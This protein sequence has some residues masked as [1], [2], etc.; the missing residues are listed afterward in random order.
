MRSFVVNRLVRLFATMFAVSFITFFMV[1]LLPGD[2]ALQMLPP[3]ALTEENIAR[4]RADLNL[5][6]PLPAR[7]VSWISGVVTG[8]LGRS[9]RTNEP[10]LDSIRARLPVTLQIAAFSI[11]FALI[12]AIPL[13]TISAYKQGRR[14][15][16][17]ISSSVQFMLS[18]PVFVAAVFLI[19]VFAVRLQWLPAT[20]WTRLTNS[21]PGN[22]R[23][24]LLPALSLSLVEIAIYT[25][26]VRADMISTLQENFVLSARAKGLTNRFILFRH[27]L[28]PS[29][30]SLITVVGLNIGTLLGG[31]VVVERIFALPGL[32][33]L[34]IDSIQQ[35][36][37]LVVQGVVLFI[38]VVYVV[39]NTLVDL[40]Y[41]AV[42]P[43]IRV[44]GK[45]A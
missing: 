17:I 28:R 22:L 44:S 45:G 14:A 11:V 40:V 21:V 39:V 43:R 1:N 33:G 42:D 37:L 10:V 30:L 18:V 36:D 24:V 23:S 5:D 29:S 25:R 4:V 8:D 31:T 38:A 12:L 2:P 32:G 35:R 16:K 41:A 26:L 15:D 9:Y 27:A 13:G 34:L 20:G 3:D 6:D 7:Y 19:Y